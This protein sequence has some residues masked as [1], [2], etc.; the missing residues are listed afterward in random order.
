M[1]LLED[2]VARGVDKLTVKFAEFQT[3]AL[4]AAGSEDILTAVTDKKIRVH[5]LVLHSDKTT[6]VRIRSA[7]ATNL[8]GAMPIILNEGIAFQFNPVGWF[9]TTAGE[10]LNVLNGA[11]VTVIFSGC[12]VY[13]EA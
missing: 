2:I 9:E 8:T 7:A 3:A 5:A 4:G 1:S 6:T 13:T 11:G 10:P 12:I